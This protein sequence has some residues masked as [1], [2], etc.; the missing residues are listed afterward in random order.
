LFGYYVDQLGYSFPGLTNAHSTTISG[1]VAGFA[2]VVRAENTLNAYVKAHPELMSKP[3]SYNASRSASESV[4]LLESTIKPGDLVAFAVDYGDG[5]GDNHAHFSVYVGKYNGVYYFAHSGASGRGPELIT[6]DALKNGSGKSGNLQH[7]EAAYRVLDQGGKLT[8]NKGIASDEDIVADCAKNYTIAGAEYGVYDTADTLVGT[9]VTDADGVGYDK[10]NPTNAYLSLMGG[11]YTVKEL[12][13]PTGYSK[14]GK[15]YEVTV[16]NG[17]TVNLS[18][19]DRPIFDPLKIVLTKTGYKNVKITGAQFT[20]TYYE[21]AF[22]KLS[23]ADKYTPK[24]TWVFETDEDGVFSF[25]PEYLVSG[26]EVPF[27]DFLDMYV[28]PIGT[29]VVEETLVPEHYTKADS[30]IISATAD[31]TDYLTADGTRIITTEG[32]GYALD[33]IKEGYLYITKTST[34]ANFPN[35]VAGAE[36][37]VY[38]DDKATKPALVNNTTDIAVLKIEKQDDAFISQTIALAPGTYYLKETKAPSGYALDKTIHSVNVAEVETATLSL[39]DRPE[40]AVLKLQK[41]KVADET[42]DP[43]DDVGA[44]PHF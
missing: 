23:D 37:T 8:L 6:W 19:E 4:K 28:V 24:K 17:N 3:V 39:Q 12:V 32:D 38:T 7:I 43:S 25:D 31:G 1:N 30:F 18:V 21:E 15:T 14:D 16:E 11:T 13:A 35:T 27:S 2:S 5:T 10:A 22:T 33:E 40:T 34:D 36:Y 29:I 26:D 41:V 42:N 44:R 9:F 20:L